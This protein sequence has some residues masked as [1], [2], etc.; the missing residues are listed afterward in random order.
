M[1]WF[2]AGLAFAFF[3]AITMLIN[4]KYKLDGQLISGMRGVGVAALY[5]P[6]LFFLTP[7]T[8]KTF[9]MLIVAEGLISTFYNARLY[10][11]SGRYGASSTSLI[12]VLSIAIG[13]VFWW[14][15]YEN[16][17][18]S[19][20]NTPAAFTGIVVSLFL[21]GGGFFFMTA[22]SLKK[23]EIAYMM[24]AV[25]AVAIMMIVRKEIMMHADFMSA[26]AY[27][28]AC[29]HIFQRNGQPYA[30]FA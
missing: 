25:I 8:N 23:G 22:N 12:N 26:M 5:L 21:V 1:I 11:S 29:A 15:L 16:R 30:L 9:W 6:A 27:Y 7:P 19:L 3:G 17:F 10:E 28:C 14:I 20:I 13:M 4:Q 2:T 24:P 18:L